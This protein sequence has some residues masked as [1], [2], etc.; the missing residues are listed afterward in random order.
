LDG[1][2]VEEEGLGLGLEL[3]ALKSGFATKETFPSPPPCSRA[4]FKNCGV[5]GE[6]KV[7]ASLDCD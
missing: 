3:D 2:E 7:M 4:G 6:V 5:T 1:G